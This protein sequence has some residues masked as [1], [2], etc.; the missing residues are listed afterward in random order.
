MMEL[1]NRYE[2]VFVMR[3]NVACLNTDTLN[4]FM[5]G[6]PLGV[7][8]FNKEFTQRVVKVNLQTPFERR[9]LLGDNHPYD[10]WTYAKNFKVPNFAK[11]T[12]EQSLGFTEAS[13]LPG[14]RWKKQ[15]LVNYLARVGSMTVFP[16]HCGA[17]TDEVLPPPELLEIGFGLYW[18]KANGWAESHSGFTD[19]YG[20]DTG[21]EAALR[22][23]AVNTLVVTGVVTEI[24]VHATA[25]DAKR[26]GFD[27]F[28]VLDAIAELSPDGGRKA[29]LDLDRQGVRFLTS[30][31][32][33]LHY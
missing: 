15:N 31:Q 21:L 22:T 26:R 30:D 3:P 10:S 12:Y 19:A 20:D 32:I 25:E 27:V 8:G 13:F 7:P 16:E 6:Y 14:M 23:R 11:I 4:G 18:P 33:Q 24:C 9:V 29:L 2:G 17:G 28:V 5:E 1:K